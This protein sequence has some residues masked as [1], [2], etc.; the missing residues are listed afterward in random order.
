MGRRK[1]KKPATS[2]PSFLNKPIKP[3]PKPK[4]EGPDPD[5]GFEAALVKWIEKQKKP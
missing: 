3:A 4:P 5:P 2:H 1:K